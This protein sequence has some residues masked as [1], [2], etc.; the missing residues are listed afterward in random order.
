[1]RFVPYDLADPD[2]L[3]EAR[4]QLCENIKAIEEGGPVITPV[5]FAE[6]MQSL[7]AGENRDA[8]VRALFE[9]LN[10]GMSNLQEGIAEVVDDLR[11]RKHAETWQQ[12]SIFTVPGLTDPLSGLGHFPVPASGFNFPSGRQGVF[13]RAIARHEKIQKAAEAIKKAKEAT[14]SKDQK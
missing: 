11:Q 2:S 14:E 9:S 5:Q 12:Q 6:I 1:M 10:T 7:K 13:K 4:K 8:Q 3:G